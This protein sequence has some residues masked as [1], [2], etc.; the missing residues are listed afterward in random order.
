MFHF[1]E[2]RKEILTEKIERVLYFYD[3]YQKK[4]DDYLNKI[5]FIQEAPTLEIM[6]L[7]DHCLVV[8]DDLMHYPQNLITKIL[9][10][11]LIISIF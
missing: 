2:N 4:F 6:K 10:C 7:A 8:L 11:M 9:L 1:I 5:E 3:M